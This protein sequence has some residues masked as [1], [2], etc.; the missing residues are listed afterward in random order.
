MLKSKVYKYAHLIQNRTE[1]LIY[2]ERSDWTNILLWEN[3]F[4]IQKKATW[5]SQYWSC[6]QISR[7]YVYMHELWIDFI[8]TKVSDFV[9][10]TLGNQHYIHLHILV[11]VFHFLGI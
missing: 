1:T 5:N 7:N 6:I 2:K 9:T 10:Q 11:C 8:P 4:L 3:Y